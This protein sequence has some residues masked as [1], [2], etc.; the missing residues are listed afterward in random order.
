[1]NE[2]EELTKLPTLTITA[3]A[4][5]VEAM[6][7]EEGEAPRLLLNAYNGGALRLAGFDLP[8]VVDIASLRTRQDIPL[9]RDHDDKRVIGHSIDLTTDSAINATGVLSYPSEDTDRVKASSKQKFPWQ[10]SI[11][12]EAEDEGM[13]Y[14]Y[15]KGSS[16]NVNGRIFS[17][18]VLVAKGF[19]LS[20]FSLVPRGADKTTSSR[21]A[22]SFTSF[23]PTQDKQ[24]DNETPVAEATPDVEASATE[25]PVTDTAT[26]ADSEVKALRAEHARIA[27]I[28]ALEGDF[29]ALKAEA[30]QSGKS[31]VEA[32]LAILRAKRPTVRA[33]APDTADNAKAIRAAFELSCGVNE[34]TVLASYGENAV[35]TGSKEYRGMGLQGLARAINASAGNEDRFGSATDSFRSA[36]KAAGVFSTLSLPEILSDTANKIL[37][38]TY[39]GADRVGQQLCR[40]ADVSDFKET[41]AVRL[42][43]VSGLKEL[44]RGGEID[45]IELAEA[46]YG[47]QARTL[48]G[49]IAID[50]RDIINDDASA[51]STIP[52]D[53]GNLAAD[54]IELNIFETLKNVAGS[55]TSGKPLSIENVAAAQA[56]MRLQKKGKKFLG[57]KMTYLVVP[58]Q[59]EAK[60]LQLEKSVT[61]DGEQ[62]NFNSVAGTFTTVVSENLGEDATTWYAVSGRVQ[63]IGLAWLRGSNRAPVVE[64]ADTD[65]N[66]LGVQMRVYVD[67][68]VSKLDP[69][70]AMAFS[71]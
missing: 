14:R 55:V 15:E 16:V 29:P 31:P 70:G 22:A 9:L 57:T 21:L 39:L 25:A 13:V 27:S 50:R 18:P 64:T 33:S 10:V 32:E 2:P 41:K 46:A 35:A 59:L 17:G 6:E 1:M 20:E 60:A 7:T 23:S 26:D 69:A 40:V 4:S 65:F 56:A 61:V 52:V 42:D 12:A 43:F 34:K 28:Q 5:K 53:L 67:A 38:D 11:G 45:H 71:A 30:I 19:S 3:N 62:G 8:L 51:L 49:M 24:M 48:A 66:T 54:T 58:P 63:P 47:M 68:G 37:L 36:I 44:P